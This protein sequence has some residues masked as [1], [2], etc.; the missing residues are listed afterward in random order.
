MDFFDNWRPIWRWLLFI[1]LFF[2][3]YFLLNML[4]SISLGRY[5]GPY[6]ESS[7]FSFVFYRFYID[8]ICLGASIVV[9]SMCIP[10]GKIVIASIYLAFILI[11]FGLSLS[12]IMF[13]MT[14][15]PVWKLIY[16]SITSILG[17][18]GGLIFVINLSKTSKGQ[19]STSFVD[20]G[21]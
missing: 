4:N 7:V 3:T 10:K 20:I 8:T 9:S 1:P 2:I 17:G 12:T 13:N 19:E 18:V 5:I 15:Y 14:Y 6:D 21:N 16:S 11:M